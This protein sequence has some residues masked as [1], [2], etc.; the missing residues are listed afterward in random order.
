MWSGEGTNGNAGNHQGWAEQMRKAMMNFFMDVNIQTQPKVQDSEDSEQKDKTKK[1]EPDSDTK[2]D[3]QK[4]DVVEKTGTV[5]GYL[6]ITLDVTKEAPI[7]KKILKLAKIA[8]VG[9]FTTI[10]VGTLADVYLTTHIDPRTGKPYRNFPSFERSGNEGT[11]T[12]RLQ[13][14]TN[15]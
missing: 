6:G 8:E 15:S 3:D 10:L 2:E 5:A 1:E 9:S 12:T 4:A 7:A 14:D 13:R 11:E